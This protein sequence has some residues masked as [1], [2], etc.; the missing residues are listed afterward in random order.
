MFQSIVVPLDGSPLAAHA[1]DYATQV[2]DP[3]AH[4]MLIAVVDIPV[5]DAFRAT[6]EQAV[7]EMIAHSQEVLAR[8]L[9]ERAQS[10]RQRGFAVATTIRTGA[11]TE[12]ILRAAADA[13]ADLIAMASHGAGGVSRWLLGSVTNRVLHATTTPLFVAHTQGLIEPPAMDAIVVPLD[14]S[15]F[16]ESAIPAAEA[17]ATRLALPVQFVRV[18]RSQS[19]ISH[20][21][22]LADITILRELAEH[23]RATAEEY[24]KVIVARFTAT[25]VDASAQVLVGNPPEQL[26]NYLASQPRA[27]VMMTTYGATGAARWIFGS[28]TEKILAIMPNPALVLH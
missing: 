10:L 17:L 12:E 25:A 1:L 9:E 15:R 11:A 28:I 21:M 18:V 7:A 16:A 13:R 5:A 27:L 6:H 22:L 20:T 8:E 4:F 2:A 19:V 26:A 24:L 14:G 3:G 23:E